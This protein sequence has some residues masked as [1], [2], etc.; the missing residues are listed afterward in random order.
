[1]AKWRIELH[2]LPLSQRKGKEGK[3]TKDKEG[4]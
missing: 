1:M 2:F 4:Q 3:A